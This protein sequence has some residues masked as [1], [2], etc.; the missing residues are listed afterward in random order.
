M[1]RFRALHVH[2]N[3]QRFL[4]KP[5]VHEQQPV[6]TQ[7]TAPMQLRTRATTI[8]T[9][10]RTTCWIC[11]S[12]SLAFTPAHSTPMLCNRA[13]CAGGQLRWPDEGFTP[14]EGY[15]L[16]DLPGHPLPFPQAQKARRPFL[17]RFGV[18]AVL[19]HGAYHLL[20]LRAS[21][22]AGKQ[23]AKRQRV[24]PL[25]LA[26]A[27]TPHTTPT[28]LFFFVQ[29]GDERGVFIRAGIHKLGTTVL[30][31]RHVYAQ[32]CPYPQIGDAVRSCCTK[33]HHLDPSSTGCPYILPKHIRF[34]VHMCALFQSESCDVHACTTIAIEYKSKEYVD[35]ARQVT[36]RH[37]HLHTHGAG[38][39]PDVLLEYQVRSYFY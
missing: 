28:L 17:L 2:C 14:V 25:P 5:V 39:K 35:L 24:H 11:Q 1:R 15:V 27:H 36:L 8:T 26:L 20:P 16:L 21:S 32:V 31:Q 19:E 6:V 22:S 18:V 23:R 29:Q 7:T 3:S 9:T 34:S 33:V 38:R 30:Q 37:T 12:H 13:I 10:A 4:A